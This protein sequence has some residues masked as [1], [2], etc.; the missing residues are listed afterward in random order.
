M[1][2][3]QLTTPESSPA[4]VV[5]RTEQGE[6]EADSVVVA[7]GN[8]AAPLLEGSP[9]LRRPGDD[10]NGGTS[11]GGIAEE[12]RG[13]HVPTALMPGILVHTPPAGQPGALSPGVSAD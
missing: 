4:V 6:F 13:F 2:E 11:T 7:L 9:S 10:D 1:L 8:G 5:V 12:C 3:I